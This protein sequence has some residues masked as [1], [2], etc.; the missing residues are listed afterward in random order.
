MDVLTPLLTPRSKPQASSKTQRH[1]SSHGSRRNAPGNSKSSKAKSQGPATPATISPSFLFVVNELQIDFEPLPGEEHLLT[2]QWLNPMPPQHAA[3]YVDEI[4]GTV[5][6]Y[7]NGA[8]S[9]A[10]NYAW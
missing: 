3:A 5:F 8:V 2:D 10:R 7:K 9:P 6:R 4:R 1:G